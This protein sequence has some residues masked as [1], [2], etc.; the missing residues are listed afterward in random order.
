[1]NN[2][3]SFGLRMYILEDLED[4][5]GDWVPFLEEPLVEESWTIAG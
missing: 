5:D 2:L 4:L 1:M 3:N